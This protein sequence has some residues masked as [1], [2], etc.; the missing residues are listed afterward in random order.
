MLWERLRKRTLKK[1]L[2]RRCAASNLDEPPH[3]KEVTPIFSGLTPTMETLLRELEKSLATM[4]PAQRE[5]TTAALV[6]IIRASGGMKDLHLS[7]ATV[8]RALQVMGVGMARGLT[9]KNH[10]ADASKLAPKIGKH[11]E[12]LVSALTQ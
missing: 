7:R 3:R 5:A 1:R 2:I 4:S 10:L 8:M 12:S 9:L 6:G 11:V